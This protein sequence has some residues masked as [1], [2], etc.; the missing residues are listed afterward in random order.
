MLRATIVQM[1]IKTGTLSLEQARSMIEDGSPLHW[2]T[3]WIGFDTNDEDESPL[4]S[5]KGSSLV[6]RGDD[7]DPDGRHFFHDVLGIKP[8]NP[9]TMDHARQIVDFVLRHH[10]S[11]KPYVIPVHCYAGLF[12]SGAVVEWMRRDLGI[13]EDIDS[14]RLRVNGDELRTYNITLLKLLRA[15]HKERS[16]DA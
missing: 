11:M 15:A 7:F 12:R 9:L 14:N 16:Y 6:I 10:G 4:R 5:A 13:V 8:K 3:A 1:I 2:Q